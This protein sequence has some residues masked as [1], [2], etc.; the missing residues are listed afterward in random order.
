MNR[1]DLA[2]PD[3][4]AMRSFPGP[5]VVPNCCKRICATMAIRSGWK[6]LIFRPSRAWAL[7]ARGIQSR[8][9]RQ[10][11]DPGTCQGNLGLARSRRLSQQARMAVAFPQRRGRGKSDG[12]CDE[13]LSRNGEFGKLA[14]QYRY[15]AERRRSRI[16]GY[17]RGHRRP[18]PPAGCR[19]RCPVLIGGHSRGGVLSVAYAGMHPEQTLGVVNF[20][21]GWISDRCAISE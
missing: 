10:T 6:R 19:C 12:F 11:S 4:D 2:F 13:E 14:L 8:H 9:N 16:D 3:Q 5:A 21:G 17:R 18:S 15:C 1:I 7:S 20:V